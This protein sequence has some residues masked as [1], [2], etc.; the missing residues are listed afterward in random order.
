M[1]K[2]IAGIIALTTV[3]CTLTGCG[4]ENADDAAGTSASTTAET[5]AAQEE[6]TEGEA[7]SAASAETG[8]YEDAVKEFVEAYIANDRQKT[9][10]MQY[11]DGIMDF[12]KVFMR[13]DEAKEMTEEDIIS[14]LQYGMYDDFDEDEKVSYKGIVSAKPMRSDE[15]D[16]IKETYSTVK[17][18]INYINEHGGPDKADPDELDDAWDDFDFDEYPCEVDIEEGYYVTFEVEDDESDTTEGT[19]YVVRIKGENGWKIS[20]GDI[21]GN[22]KANRN[23]SLNATA[24]TLSK[25]L[26]TTLVDMDEEGKLPV[27]DKTFIVSS[28][29]SMNYNVPDD[30]DVELLRKKA[31]NYF[32]MMKELE[33]FA[34]I[35]NGC[36]V[37]DAADYPDDQQYVGTYPVNSIMNKVNTENFSDYT[38]EDEKSEERTF[39]ELYDIC[40]EVI[41]K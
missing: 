40:V 6:T 41:G 31:L 9:L 5:T 14:F 27:S 37:Y 29:D 11:P 30:F 36:V 7:N 22:I 16:D 25:A 35:N 26:N 24:S 23:D 2:V 12:V 19:L 13:T 4:K 20:I 21:H 3:L 15:E 18:T 32:E 38:K 1:K 34:V 17:W 8:A 39:K 33:W 28:D 10:E